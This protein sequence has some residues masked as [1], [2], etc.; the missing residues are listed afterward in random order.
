MN[1]TLK[2]VA[3]LLDLAAF[4]SSIY[5]Y[6]ESK[7][8]EAL[9]SMITTFGVLVGLI[10]INF[11]RNSLDNQENQNNKKNKFNQKAGKNSTQ[12]QSGGDMTINNK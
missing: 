1:K 7:E 10:T 6:S 9:I 2:T 4:A 11:D 5:W 12:Y 3:L 8:T